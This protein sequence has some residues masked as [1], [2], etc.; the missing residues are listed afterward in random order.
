LSADR[1]RANQAKHKRN[2]AMTHERAPM[3]TRHV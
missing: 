1:C 2:D 3:A